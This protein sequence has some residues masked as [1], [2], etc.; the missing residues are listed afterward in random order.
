MERDC[1]LVGGWGRNGASAVKASQEANVVESSPSAECD[2][3]AQWLV[4][5]GRVRGS[6]LIGGASSRFCSRA[7]AIG[8]HCRPLGRPNAERRPT[9][10][11]CASGSLSLRRL[12]D[13]ACDWP[14]SRI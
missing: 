1:D 3:L 9:S 14:R 7:G 6:S 8:D 5:K 12:N 13:Y 2:R 4:R 11:F 10:F